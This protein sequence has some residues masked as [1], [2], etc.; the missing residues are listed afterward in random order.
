MGV[1]FKPDVLLVPILLPHVLGSSHL[2]SSCLGLSDGAN[3]ITVTRNHLPFVW[4]SYDVIPSG[5]EAECWQLG[6]LR[7]LLK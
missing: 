1:G 4:S 2:Y 7:V 5:R 6:F 3:D